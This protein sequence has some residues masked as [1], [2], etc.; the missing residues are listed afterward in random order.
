MRLSFP[1]LQR[2]AARCQQSALHSIPG[3]AGGARG[4]KVVV[5]EDSKQKLRTSMTSMSPS[6]GGSSSSSWAISSCDS[7]A[8]RGGSG[9]LAVTRVPSLSTTR[10][11][12]TRSNFPNAWEAAA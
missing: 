12:H 2:G 7:R 8:K 3:D 9:P 6:C 5:Q 1:S 11:E 10:P 4:R